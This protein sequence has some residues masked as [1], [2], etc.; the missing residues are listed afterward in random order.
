[1]G[2]HRKLRFWTHSGVKVVDNVTPSESWSS[3]DLSSVV[4]SNYAFV[5]FAIKNIA[6]SG[7][8]LYFFRPC[9]AACVGD[10]ATTHPQGLN[11]ICVDEGCTGHIA[12]E[13][14]ENGK[15]Q[16]KVADP[17]ATDV[18]VLGYVK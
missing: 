10:C 12:L 18:W 14:D 16:W 17:V 9:S 3:L 5:F 8:S 11:Q 6:L 2:I 15:I 4:G 1:M 7:I 13:T